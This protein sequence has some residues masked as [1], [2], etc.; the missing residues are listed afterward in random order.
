MQAIQSRF[1][2]CT[3]KRWSRIKAWCERGSITVSCPDEL[4]GEACH[5]AAVDALLAKFAKEDE[6]KYGPGNHHWG[7][8][9][10]GQLPGGD[11]AHVLTR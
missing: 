10:T 1:L 11:Y 3:N 6:A 7:S 4:S 2:P 8:F 9:V 5:R